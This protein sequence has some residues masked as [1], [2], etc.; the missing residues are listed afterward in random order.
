M[1]IGWIIYIALGLFIA[2]CVHKDAINRE[3]KNSEL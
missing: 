3:I 2:F 1:T